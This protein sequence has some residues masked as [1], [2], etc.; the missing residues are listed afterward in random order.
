M[1]RLRW[2]AGA[3]LAATLLA[4]CGGSGQSGGSGSEPEAAS[5]GD[6]AAGETLL[7][8]VAAGLNGYLAP[9]DQTTVQG[10][11]LWAEEVN[12]D[13][14][15]DGRF[16]VE[17]DV[18]DTRS[19]VAQTVVVAQ[20]VLD[21]GAQVLL[22]P[23]DVDPSIAA[24]QLAQ[25]QQI[26]AFSLCSSTPTLAPAVGDFFFQNFAADNVQAAVLAQHAVDE[27]YQTAYVLKSPDTPYTQK[28]PEYFVEA[29]E[30]KG[31]EVLAQDTYTLG[32]QNFGSQVDRIRSLEPDVI[33]T[34]AY[35]PDFPAFIRQVRSAGIEAPVLGSDGIDS[36]TTFE[37]GEVVDGVVFSTP[38]FPTEGSPLEEFNQRFEAHFGE[39]SETIFNAIG[40]DIGLIIQE[41]VTQAG[42]LDPVAI[43]D[44]I[45]GIEDL[46]LATGTVTYAGTNGVPLR[47]V[48]LVRI[49]ANGERSLVTQEVPP[50]D[51]IPEP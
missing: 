31:G 10:L 32:Q 48:S 11:E 44:A 21:A 37:L 5:G 16:P 33:M 23:C 50:A 7:I 49:G 45:A 30:G 40:Y 43:R 4:A 35:E 34:S 17:L 20:E 12:Q 29:F 14:G 47:E 24:G 18:R 38:G 36:P 3:V 42:S 41:A 1:V 26:P 25:E 46:Q 15:I 8:G 6:Q 9:Y 51:E 13:G 19:E 28:L 2:T 22:T 39:P 27:G